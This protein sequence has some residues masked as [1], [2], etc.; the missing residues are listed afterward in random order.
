MANEYD[1]VSDENIG[2]FLD[3]ISEMLA[4]I[5]DYPHRNPEAKQYTVSDYYLMLTRCYVKIQGLKNKANVLED[6]VRKR[7]DISF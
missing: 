7:V 4:N 6:N 2:S 3:E 5:E 1:Y